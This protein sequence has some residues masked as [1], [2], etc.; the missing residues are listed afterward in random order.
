MNWT[1]GAAACWPMKIGG[2]CAKKIPVAWSGQ[3]HRNTW[4]G[5]GLH[6]VSEWPSLGAGSRSQCLHGA[7]LIRRKASSAVTS[8]NDD[9]PV[10]AEQLLIT[11]W[12]ADDAVLARILFTLPT[13]CDA[14][15]S[16]ECGIW[17]VW[18]YN[19]RCRN[20]GG[21]TEGRYSEI[22]AW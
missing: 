12:S 1:H 13:K 16:A 19:Y 17:V 14:R 4:S 10:S 8:W 5:I 15:S 9:K 3:R 22:F 11:L 6:V 18:L 20:G 2:S 21:E 7:R